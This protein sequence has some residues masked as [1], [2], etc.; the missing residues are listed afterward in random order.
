MSIWWW[1][2]ST[3]ETAILEDEVEHFDQYLRAAKR[4]RRLHKRVE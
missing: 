4:L 3:C 2:G 1:V